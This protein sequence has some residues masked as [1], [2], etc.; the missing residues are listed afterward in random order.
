MWLGRGKQVKVDACAPS[1]KAG[2]V[3]R[4]FPDATKA[5]YTRAKTALKNQ[6][7]PESR[8]ALYQTRLHSRMRQRGDGWADLGDDLKTLADN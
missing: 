8:R 2:S 1:G 3:F 5:D 4:H 6:F 7:E